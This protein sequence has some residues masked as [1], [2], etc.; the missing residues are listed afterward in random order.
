MHTRQCYAFCI[1][2][3][4]R[5]CRPEAK[6]QAG[7]LRLGD[8]LS[9]EQWQYVSKFGF[10]LGAGD[11]KFRLRFREIRQIERAVNL[12]FDM[13]L[14]EDWHNVERLPACRRAMDGP[15]RATTRVHVPSDG[16]WSWWSS[17][18]VEQVVRPHIWYFALSSC[19][20]TSP[21]S[22][23]NGTVLVDFEIHARQCGGSE[24]SVEMQHMFPASMAAL[25]AFS[26]FLFRYGVLCLG[27]ARSAGS[28]HLVVCALTVAMILQ[29][30]GQALQVVHLWRYKDDGVGTRS[31]DILSEILFM[32]SQALQTTLLIAIALGYTLLHSTMDELALVK[33]I[34]L[35]VSLLHAGLVYLGKIHGDSS[36]KYHENEGIVG[37]LLLV[38]RLGLYLWFIIAIQASQQKSGFRLQLF[39]RQFQLAGSIYFLAYPLIFSVVQVFAPYLR[40]PIMQT[41]LFAM[42][43]TSHIWLASLFLF[44][45][46]YFKA[47]ML[48]S[49]LLP[50]CGGLCIQSDKWL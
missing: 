47:S 14:D 13:F 30:I 4:L 17:G 44:R 22:A 18:H 28:V 2:L 35:G 32:M 42:Q 41:G 49:S 48:S 9:D 31:F 12:N 29:Y 39:F 37:Y 11:Y 25:I 43:M 40:H 7:T 34:A 10:G 23:L 38:I 5:F 8:D 19:G 21:Y 15:S 27:V 24:F 50:S 46:T 6:F 45:G 20:Q 3:V 1:A 16:E 36:Y 26:A 33:P